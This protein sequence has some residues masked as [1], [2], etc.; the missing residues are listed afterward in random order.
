MVN[1]IIYAVL[2]FFLCVL[3]FCVLQ[4]PL[5]IMYNKSLN[6]SGMSW[7]DLRHIYRYGFIT[8]LIGAAYLTSVPILFVLIISYIP[9]VDIYLCLF[10]C[11]LLIAVIFSLVSLSDT[12]LYRFWQFKIDSSV[13][14]Y[15][16]HP[17]AAFS[18]VSL[19]Y[20]IVLLFCIIMSVLLSFTVLF[21][22]VRF[23]IKDIVLQVLSTSFHFGFTGLCLLVLT[24]LFLVIRGVGH[25]PNNPCVA[26]YSETPFFNHCALNPLYSLL[27]SFSI[28]DDFD[29]QFKVFDENECR[30]EFARLF[31]V[32]GTPEIKLLKTDRPN[33]LFII[34]ESLS[35]RYMETLGGEAGVMPNI[36]RLS[37]EGV[38]F[39]RCD[40][41]SFRTDRGL[42]CLL[43]GYLGQPTTSVIRHTK[44]LPNL[45]A[46]P[47]VLKKNGYKTMA[48]HGGN[49]QV[50]HKTDYY[51]ATGHD[52]LVSQKELPTSAP[53]CKWGIN[54]GYTF[55]WLYD[56][57][58]NKTEHNV[59]WYTTF[60]TLSSHEPFDVPFKKL[61]DEKKNAFAYVDECFGNFIGKLKS[62]PAWDDL[63]VIC[64]G[65]H[66]F[67][68]CAPISRDKF[69][70]IP[71]LLLGGAI[72]Q[73]LK[74]DKIMAQT[75]IAAT[76]LGQLGINHDEFVFSRDVLAD[77]YT[78]PFA[79]HTYNNGFFFR[80]DTGFT[81]YD[82]VAGCPVENADTR[83]EH[84][85]KVILQTLY[86]DLSKR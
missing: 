4:R 29:G 8:D 3:F 82:N 80:D 20:V 81:N 43:S 34:W 62:S 31:P 49:C 23:L 64:T 15:L 5:F 12:A 65:D 75:D 33:I 72:R 41:G 16:R 54:D 51:L 14:V 13:L 58:M 56:D 37:E 2:H 50:M 85:A 40:C 45:P 24:V 19:K 67:N 78:Y 42:V 22:S 36:E 47:R 77:T 53:T 27:Y 9:A 57:I 74:F 70:H 63:L 30:T 69:V 59:R 68:Y 7:R 10:L 71:V 55:D 79:L 11:E 6:K 61:Q 60:Q 28:K 66:G 76:L 39:T 35:A 44:K 21:F 18:S 32:K 83:R 84:V 86:E 48:L 1:I 52:T 26:Y 17:K 46:L 38:L 73:P 25:R